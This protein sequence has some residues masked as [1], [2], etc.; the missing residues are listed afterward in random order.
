MT[1]VGVSTVDLGRLMAEADREPVDWRGRVR[2]VPARNMTVVPESCGR[3]GWWWC[4]VLACYPRVCGQGH[5]MIS[6]C[7][8]SAST[9]RVEVDPSADPDLYTML[10]HAVA[11]LSLDSP[12]AAT[13]GRL[14]VE[15]ARMRDTV[16][17]ALTPTRLQQVT[18]GAQVRVHNVTVLIDRLRTA[19]LLAEASRSPRQRID[20]YDLTFPAALI[21]RADIR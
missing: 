8:L 13:L 17:L 5:A 12:A 19:G 10:W 4:L 14:L 3:D 20:F 16:T 11:R 6:P 2:Y 1:I 9:D 15:V 7:D 18:S 21:Q